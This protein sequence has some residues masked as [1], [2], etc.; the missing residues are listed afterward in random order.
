MLISLINTAIPKS[1]Y[2]QIFSKNIFLDSIIGALVGSISAG[3]SM[4]SYIMGGE[5]LIQGVSL[6]AIT[7]FLISWVTVGVLQFPAESY[8]LGKKFAIL[9]NLVS[10][11]F[12]IIAAI[13]IVLIYGNI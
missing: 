10:F 13:I 7:A 9:R 11:I 8:F 2:E 12:S 4:I 3:S 1:F 6:V 5:F